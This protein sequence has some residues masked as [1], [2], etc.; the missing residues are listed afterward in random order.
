MKNK[1]VA[2]FDFDGTLTRG[3]TFL[4]F[5]IY[6]FGTWKTFYGLVYTSPYILAYLLKITSNQYAKSKIIKIFFKEKNISQ[7]NK[8]AKKFVDNKLDKTLR[9]NIVDR[10]RWHQSQNHLTLLISAS[11]SIYVKLWAKKYKFSYIES[12]ELEENREKFTGNIKG[13]NCYG[14]EKVIRIKK[15]L[16]DS[17]T[18]YELYGYGDSKGDEYFL[19]LCDHKYSKGKLKLIKAINE[20]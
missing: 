12:T 5:L 2:I 9:K 10:L 17:Q 13:N 7:I 8:L 20:Y 4:P 1:V 16:N 11:L 14:Y 15:I 18:N 19:K 3:D 6:T